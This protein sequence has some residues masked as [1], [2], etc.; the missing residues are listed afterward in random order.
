MTAGYAVAAYACG[1][2]AWIISW[3]ISWHTA[4]SWSDKDQC[5]VAA[6][7]LLLSPV[8]PVMAVLM[9]GITVVELWKDADWRNG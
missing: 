8:W 3:G 4:R 5:R 6:R 1:L 7:M 9:V 2:G